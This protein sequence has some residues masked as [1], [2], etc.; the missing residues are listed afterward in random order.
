MCGGVKGDR[1]GEPSRGNQS[2]GG[3]V[4]WRREGMCPNKNEEWVGRHMEK[5]EEWDTG[6]LS[7]SGKVGGRRV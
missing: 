4:N 3:G 2:E 6:R 5:R 7:E 1:R